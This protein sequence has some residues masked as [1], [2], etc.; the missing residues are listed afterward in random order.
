MISIIVIIAV[1]FLIGPRTFKAVLLYSMGYLNVLG[2]PLQILSFLIWIFL[3]YLP[4][5]I[6]LGLSLVLSE[7]IA[8]YEYEQKSGS[9]IKYSPYESD[10]D[11]SSGL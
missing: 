2:M 11:Y 1:S 3:V 8:F 10:S 6:Y 5:K 9:V 7:A 4:M